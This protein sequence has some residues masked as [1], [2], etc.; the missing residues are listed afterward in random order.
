MPG[1]LQL[2]D[3]A[4]DGEL[5]VEQG[6]VRR[7]MIVSSNHGESVR[8]LSWLDFGYLRTVSD[9]GKTILFEE[10]GST[11]QGYTVFVRDVDGSPA[12]ALGQGYGAGALRVTSVGRWAES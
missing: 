7:G 9:D 11:S 8:D 2:Q 6:L 4:A 5:L 10:E 1:R 3:I 12:V